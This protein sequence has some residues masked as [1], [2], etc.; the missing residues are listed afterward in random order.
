[1]SRTGRGIP[2][3]VFR[4]IEALKQVNI[5]LLSNLIKSLIMIITDLE[6]K[7]TFLLYVAFEYNQ[8]KSPYIIDLLDVF[9]SETNLVLVLEYMTADLADIISSSKFQLPLSMIK[10]CSL[11]VI[12]G[13]GHCHSHNIIHRDIKPSNILINNR[14]QVKIA[15][16]GY[17]VAWQICSYFAKYIII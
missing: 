4:E 7:L 13:V 2:R 10:Y 17:K 12:E 11:A 14:G 6:Y 16:F 3:A 8:L 1:M 15:D 5:Y 9:P